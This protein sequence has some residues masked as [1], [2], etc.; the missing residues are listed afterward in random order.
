MIGGWKSAKMNCYPV[1]RGERSEPKMYEFIS[2]V[3]TALV[4]LGLFII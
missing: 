2:M 1:V 3:Q 4:S